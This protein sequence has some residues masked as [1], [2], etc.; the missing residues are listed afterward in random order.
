MQFMPD[1][2]ERLKLFDEEK[3]LAVAWAPWK[4][5]VHRIL[6]DLTQP[7]LIGYRRAPFWQ[8][9]WHMVDVEPHDEAKA[10]SKAKTATK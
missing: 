4:I 5:H 10:A 2:P 3:R 8:E 7:W 1:G 6:N 9:W